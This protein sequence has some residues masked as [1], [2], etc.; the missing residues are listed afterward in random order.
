MKTSNDVIN[1][2]P[3]LYREHSIY[4]AIELYLIDINKQV[5]SNIN[6]DQL[7][8][9]VKQLRFFQTLLQKEEKNLNFREDFWE[10]YGYISK[11]NP[12]IVFEC[13]IRR[14]SFSKF[15]SKVS[16][17][18]QKGKPIFKLKDGIGMRYVI[19]SNSQQESVSLCYSIAEVIIEF[20][21]KVKNYT[22]CMAEELNGCENF[23]TSKFRDIYIPKEPLLSKHLRKNVKDYIFTPKADSG[24]QSLHI[25]F[26]DSLGNP[27]EVQIRTHEMDVRYSQ[28]HGEYN[29]KKYGFDNSFVNHLDLSKINMD[30][31]SIDLNGN[32]KDNIGLVE[33][34]IWGITSKSL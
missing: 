20:F 9:L 31:F 22:L 19:Y 15:L 3:Y 25:A 21:T 30:G 11:N 28:C 6:F 29:E 18:L 26:L 4:D 16:L 32:L 14:K 27:F 12:N 2:L 33:P 10:C 7:E 5:L 34:K 13:T 1:I 8:S 17:Y 24:Y 23:D